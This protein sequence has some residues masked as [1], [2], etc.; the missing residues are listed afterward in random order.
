MYGHFDCG[1]IR[2]QLYPNEVPTYFSVAASVEL[3]WWPGGRADEL[4]DMAF[5]RRHPTAPPFGS[6][7]PGGQPELC[8]L[9]GA[10]IRDGSELYAT[11]A[12]S[13]AV[14]PYRP[15]LD[16]QRRLVACGP[17]HLKQLVDRYRD[18]PFD[19]EELWAYILMRAQRCSGPD[20]DLDDLAD[21]TGLTIEQLMRAD[22]WQ[23]VWLQWVP[24]RT[25]GTAG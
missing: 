21:I 3:P 9:C 16:G 4:D 10:V 2:M 18:R 23:A 24:E 6:A 19:D 17:G 15:A 8:D 20:T 12:D 22:R 25:R 13:S 5:R 7:V 14:D 11:V 1:L